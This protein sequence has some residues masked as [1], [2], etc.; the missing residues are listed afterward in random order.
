MRFGKVFSSTNLPRIALLDAWSVVL[1][2]RCLRQGIIRFNEVGFQL[3]ERKVE[4]VKGSQGFWLSSMQNTRRAR[5]TLIVDCNIKKK[6]KSLTVGAGEKLGERNSRAS[7]NPT[8]IGTHPGAGD[9]RD[10]NGQ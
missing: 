3:L 1:L 4:G 2:Y 6:L 7:P 8:L 9:A 5:C 10:D